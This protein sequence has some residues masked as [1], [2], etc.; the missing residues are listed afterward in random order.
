MAATDA[1]TTDV[2][3]RTVVEAASR[4]EAVATAKRFNTEPL[5]AEERKQF[6]PSPA[7]R[8]FIAKYKAKMIPAKVVKAKANA[9]TS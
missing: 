1:R 3:T 9:I 4:K 7:E 8:E 6:R 5:S 2:V